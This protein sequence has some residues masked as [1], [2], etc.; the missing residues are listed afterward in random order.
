VLWRAR[1][2]CWLHAAVSLRASPL[3]RCSVC[4]RVLRMLR[5]LDDRWST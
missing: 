2:S 3:R 1:R 4:D 5:H